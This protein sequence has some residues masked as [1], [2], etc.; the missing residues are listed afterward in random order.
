MS[1]AA[2]RPS[3]SAQENKIRRNGNRLSDQETRNT[4][5]SDPQNSF[6]AGTGR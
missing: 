3:E 5:Q 4:Q 2:S 1:T 6:G